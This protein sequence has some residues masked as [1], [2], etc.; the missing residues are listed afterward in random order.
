MGN[1]GGDAVVEAVAAGVAALAP[2]VMPLEDAVLVE[3]RADAFVARGGG[4][5]GDQSMSRMGNEW[6]NGA[7]A[8]GGYMRLDRLPGGAW[9][10]GDAHGDL[11]LCGT[12]S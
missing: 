3:R 8:W 12:L 6:R 10:D 5:R 7:R 4:W 11:V 2:R 9:G 1:L